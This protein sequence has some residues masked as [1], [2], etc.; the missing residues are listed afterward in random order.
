[1]ST[2][3]ADLIVE[4]LAQC[5]DRESHPQGIAL[6]EA[7]GGKTLCF[8]GG[9]RAE[10]PDGSALCSAESNGWRWQ[11]EV[12]PFVTREQENCTRQREH[13]WSRQGRYEG[14]SRC[15]AMRKC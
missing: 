9:L 8:F 12:A 7:A 6:I 10:L 5:D 1:M 3:Q 4:Q 11:V 14:C 15:G 13:L 2:G